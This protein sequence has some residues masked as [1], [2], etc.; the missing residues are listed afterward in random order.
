M[1]T[2]V[3]CGAEQWVPQCRMANARGEYDLCPDGGIAF[4]EST[5]TKAESIA[6][7]QWTFS[8]QQQVVNCADYGEQKEK[9]QA[10]VEIEEVLPPEIGFKESGAED[11]RNG[12]EERAEEVGS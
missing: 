5:T 3:G 7:H 10:V 9:Y 8:I 11:G 12:K 4:S 6:G 2:L 1:A